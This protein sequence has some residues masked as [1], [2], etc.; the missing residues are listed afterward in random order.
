MKLTFYSH[1]KRLTP[2]AISKTVFVYIKKAYQEASSVLVDED[3]N[4]FK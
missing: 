3:S 4:E 1:N 2:R